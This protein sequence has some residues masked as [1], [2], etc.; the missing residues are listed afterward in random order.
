MTISGEI[1]ESCSDDTEERLKTDLTGRSFIKPQRTRVAALIKRKDLRA[2]TE[3]KTW[4]ILKT[5]AAE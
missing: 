4:K 2:L 5:L 3:C 1:G